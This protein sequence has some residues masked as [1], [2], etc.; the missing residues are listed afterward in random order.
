MRI[1]LDANGYVLAVFWGCCSGICQEYTGTVPEGYNDLHEWSENALINAYYIENGNLALDEER[2]VELESKI[3]EDTIDNEPILRKDLYGSFDVLEEQYQSETA[4][5]KVIAIDNVKKINPKVKI[6]NVES[7]LIEIITQTKNMLRNDGKSETIA[8]VTFTK[9]ISGGITITG[10]STE[11]IEYNLSGSGNNT[12]S[13]F[14]LKNGLDYYLNIGD[15]ECEM[16]Y[17][18]TTQVYLGTGGVINL[19]EDK[20]VTQV[21]LKIPSGTTLNTTIYPMLEYGSTA[22]EY[23]IYDEKRL[24][25]DASAYEN[26]EYI[27]I[28]DGLIYT[29]TNGILNYLGK[30]NVN[31]FDGFNT[32]YALQDTNLEI[33][34]NINNLKLEGTYTKDNN[35]RILEDGSIECKNATLKD[36]SINMETTDSIPLITVA[37]N[38]QGGT[39]FEQ[40]ISGTHQQIIHYTDKTKQNILEYGYYDSSSIGLEQRDSETSGI[41]NNIYLGFGME[42]MGGLNEKPVFQITKDEEVIAEI[43]E[44]CAY[45]KNIKTTPKVAQYYVNGNKDYTTGA[46]ISF[47]I[48]N[49]DTTDGDVVFENNGLIT[50]N[51]IG[52]VKISMNLW[53]RGGSSSSRPWITLRD[54]TNNREITGVIDDCS[55]GY[56]SIVFSDIYINNAVAGTQYGVY[57]ASVSGSITINGGTNTPSSY[58]NIQLF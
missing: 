6:T 37:R 27:T 31:L 7:S 52:L 26:I 4:T 29:S 55:S 51:H 15:L 58:C 30:G 23:A 44:N 14:S 32:I 45:F 56:T 49:I 13:I 41:S 39:Y 53:V 35:F 10:T 40:T 20:E 22:S 33:T 16:N 47:T 36:G 3:M 12:T 25:I 19:P 9:L 24:T 2:L 50:I 38:H 34:Y 54:Y 48:E 57:V 1:E 17:L 8:G 46:Y 28:E 42:Q 43:G 11:A 18:G 21:L 5:G